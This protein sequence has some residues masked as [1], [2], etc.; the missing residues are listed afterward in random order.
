MNNEI[1]L[2]S[3]TRRKITNFHLFFPAFLWQLID[4]IFLR[5]YAHFI[6]FLDINARIYAVFA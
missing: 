1:C 5:P 2:L 3:P 4:E 6:K